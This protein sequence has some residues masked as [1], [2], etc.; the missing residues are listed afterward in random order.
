MACCETGEEQAHREKGEEQKG[1][2][3]EGRQR[4]QAKDGPAALSVTTRKAKT[5]WEQY[6][7]NK[8]RSSQWEHLHE[9]SLS[10]GVG[11]LLQS[12]G[13]TGGLLGQGREVH[14]LSFVGQQSAV[15]VQ[16]DRSQELKEELNELNVLATKPVPKL[17][18]RPWKFKLESLQ[19]V[20]Q[21]GKAMQKV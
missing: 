1:L 8:L 11:H 15:E 5:T 12:D 2:S 10:T 14:H 4:W 3:Q 6:R 17:P 19:E 7:T 20:G 13:C 18:Q 21:P 16:S 9:E